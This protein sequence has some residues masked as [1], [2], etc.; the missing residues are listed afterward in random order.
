MAAKYA[1]T[2]ERRVAAFRFRARS[3]VFAWLCLSKKRE[4]NW[5]LESN[6]NTFLSDSSCDERRRDNSGLGEMRESTRF[7]LSL[8]ER[9]K[10]YCQRRVWISINCNK[11]LSGFKPFEKHES[12]TQSAWEFHDDESESLK[13]THP[14][15]YVGCSCSD[16]VAPASRPTPRLPRLQPWR[17]GRGDGEYGLA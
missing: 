6:S 2:R 9:M 13:A 8:L 12:P 3:C 15:P 5:C 14:L 1:R 7:G 10:V 16:G 11:N 17:L 4:T